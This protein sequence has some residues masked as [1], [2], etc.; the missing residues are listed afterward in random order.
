MAPSD[1]SIVARFDEIAAANSQRIAILTPRGSIRYGA[2][3]SLSDRIASHLGKRLAGRRAGAPAPIA[4]LLPQ[5]LPP[6]PRNSGFSRPELATCRSIRVT[7]P[8]TCGRRSD[9][10]RR[11][12]SSPTR[13]SPSLP[14]VSS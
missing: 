5:G 2:L 13:S 4:V 7:R 8:R 3:A 12:S 6:S 9:M 11:R 1:R 14:R 10:P